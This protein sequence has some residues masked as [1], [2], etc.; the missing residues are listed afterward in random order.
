[1]STC[2]NWYCVSHTNACVWAGVRAK[3]SA[4]WFRRATQQ[5]KVSE[6]QQENDSPFQLTLIFF[7]WVLLRK[8][9]SEFGFKFE[10]VTKQTTTVLLASNLDQQNCHTRTL[11]LLGRIHRSQ[12]VTQSPRNQKG[13]KLILPVQQN[14]GF[15]P[16]CGQTNNTCCWAEFEGWRFVDPPKNRK[17]KQRFMSTHKAKK[18]KVRNQPLCVVGLFQFLIYYLFI[19][20]EGS[21]R[22]WLFQ[23]NWYLLRLTGISWHTKKNPISDL[24]AFRGCEKNRF[25]R[26]QTGHFMVR[27]QAIKMSALRPHG[28]FVIFNV[29][30]KT[31]VPR[32]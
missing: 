19:S 18:K 26:W 14:K 20:N 22:P 16:N 6:R 15:Y 13:I 27:V 8:T 21:K 9:N 10:L 25:W 31:L 24:E 32:R 5:K 7:F 28:L 12:S 4:D 2:S 23:I 3:Q 1:M 29:F 17:L 11:L 30:L